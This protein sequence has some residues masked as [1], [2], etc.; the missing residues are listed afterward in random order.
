MQLKLATLSALIA[1]IALPTVA[2]AEEAASTTFNVGVV[3]DYRYRGITQ[4][5][6]DPALQGGAD[7]SNPSGLYLGTWA[8]TIQWVKDAGGK[9]DIE[10]DLYG[11][12]K[13]EITKGV[14][15]DVGGLYYLYP[16]NKLGDV[17]GLANADTFEVYG[18]ISY[19]PVTAKYSHSPTNL[20]GFIDSKQ[21][22]YL[23]L[24]ASFDL[25]NGFSLAPHIGHQAVRHSSAY[26][27]TDYSLTLG[28]DLGSGVSVSAALVGSDADKRLYL[29]P[30]GKFTGRNALV[31]G[32][33]FGF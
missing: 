20:F 17:A 28:K 5:R 25:G 2:R 7:Y 14:G 6:L 10:W 24:S 32:A 27:Y 18:A 22:G 11:G 3:T 1:A 21:S 4:S 26:S 31:L 29:T 33:R 12:V 9:S 15:F 16:N 13:G 19:G 30:A 23:D 8:S